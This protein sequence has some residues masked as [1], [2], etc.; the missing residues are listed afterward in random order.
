MV[1]RA[2]L[3]QAVAVDRT[4]Q[5]DIAACRAA[6]RRLHLRLADVDDATS[7]RASRLP[8]W[9]VGH[10]LTHLARNADSVV[11]RL[12]AASAGELVE[13]YPGGGTGRAAD[14]EAGARRPADEALA[15]LVRAD[16]AV[17]R[18]FAAADDDLWARTVRL[19]GG[20][21]GPAG[22]LV[23]RRWR[24]VEAHHVDLGLGYEWSDWP[25]ELVARWLPSLL[26]E[27]PQRAGGHALV[28]WATGRGPAPTLPPWG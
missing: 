8:G 25:D 21:T 7:A 26:T 3:L 4:L 10:V 23:F 19:G 17:D 13:Q 18:A 15:D 24:E 22:R 9:T 5:A 28:A 1:R 16:D 2:T 11:R 27:L 6:H 20:T 14:I 12:E